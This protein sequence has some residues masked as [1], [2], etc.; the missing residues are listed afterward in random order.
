[1]PNLFRKISRYILAFAAIGTLNF[2]IP[3]L[4]PGDPLVNLLGE[5]FSLTRDQV[6]D[7]REE[8][9]LDR[10]LGVQYIEYW[11]DIA[12]LDL[13]YS[14]HYSRPVASVIGNRMGW[15]LA[16]V[17]PSLIIGAVGGAVFG[18]RAGWKA[19]STGSKIATSAVL[20][21]YSIPP[22]FLALIFLY[23]FSFRLGLFP[24][25][26]YY[27]T[28]TFL[29]V[30]RHLVLPVLVLSLFTMSRNYMIMRG[31]VIQEKRKLYALY[32]RSKGIGSALVRKRHVFWN[33][34]LPLISLIAL[35]FGFIFSGAL[36]VEIIFSMNGMGT[37]IYEAI[38]ELDYPT[39]QGSFFI[40]AVMIIGFNILADLVYVL[41]DP[42]V[43]KGS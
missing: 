4:M 27:E 11:R 29:D 38:R 6:Q 36:F 22:F 28:G 13:G 35:D 8:L 19:E 2:F 21:V 5:D 3:R 15:T 41:V 31:S 43:R 12:T 17:L 32:A 18:S 9:G 30:L 34:S 23:L 25:K 20:C 14:Y 16:L 40:I 1:M 33:S 24:L 10:P 7:L 39:L 26:G 42:R 37:L